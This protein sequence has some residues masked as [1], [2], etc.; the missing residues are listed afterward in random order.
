MTDAPEQL[1]T[2]QPPAP[3]RPMTPA[4]REAFL[5]ARRNRNIFLGLSLVAFIIIVF[6]VTVLRMGGYVA[7]RPL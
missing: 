7:Q 6:L 5:K 3:P 2:P 4:E 1:P